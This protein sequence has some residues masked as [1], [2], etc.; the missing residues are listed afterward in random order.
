MS[1][2]QQ[3]IKLHLEGISWRKIARLLNVPKSTVSDFLRDRKVEMDAKTKILIFDIETSPIEVYAWSLWDKFTSIDQIIEDWSVLT[4]SAKWLGSPR[5]M[6]FYVDPSS[7]R[8]D[9]DVCESLWQLLNEADIVVAH[10]GD[11]FDIKKMNTRFL[12]HGFPEPEPYRSVDTL[13]IAK[14]KFAFTSNKL[15]YIAKATGGAGKLKHEGFNMWKRCLNG[16]AEALREM[17]EYNDVDVLELERV[18]MLMRGYDHLHPNVSLYG[19]NTEIECPTCGSSN[20]KATGN[21]STTQTDKYATYRCQEPTCG[22]ISKSRV[23]EKT[24]HQRRNII[25]P[26]K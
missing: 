14:R 19:D 23:S 7:P 3:A 26:V 24:T 6:H 25:V 18:Y 20:V 15:D 9:F 11:R 22:K 16:D 17:Q 12:L 2:H 5:M 8:D 4:I 1:W 21:Y 13:K 10:N